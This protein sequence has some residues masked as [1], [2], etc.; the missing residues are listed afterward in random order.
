[1]EQRIGRLNRLGQTSNITIYNIVQE[2]SYSERISKII[3]KKK[4]S[5]DQFTLDDLQSLLFSDP[6]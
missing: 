6:L 1:M 2:G 4:I 3:N 5:L